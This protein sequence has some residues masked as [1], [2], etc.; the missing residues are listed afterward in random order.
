MAQH[1]SVRN[2]KWPLQKV[3]SSVDVIAEASDKKAKEPKMTHEQ[4]QEANLKFHK[5]HQAQLDRD[6]HRIDD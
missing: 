1:I 4:R 5:K 2:E 6:I 3:K